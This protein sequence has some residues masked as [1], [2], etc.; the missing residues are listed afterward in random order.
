MPNIFEDIGLGIALLG[1]LIIAVQGGR[2]G[3]DEDK[4]E[5]NIE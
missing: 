1:L 3:R 4:E 5:E 2:G